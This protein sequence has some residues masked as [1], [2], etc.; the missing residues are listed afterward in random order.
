MSVESCIF[1]VIESQSP[2]SYMPGT[3][4]QIGLSLS[5]N[6]LEYSIECLVEYSSTRVK[7]EV[8]ICVSKGL[9]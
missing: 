9:S 3:V 6:L 7:R 4:I 8:E 5:Y 2:T 1:A